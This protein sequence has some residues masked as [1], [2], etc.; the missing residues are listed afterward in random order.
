MLTKMNPLG[1]VFAHFQTLKNYD[2]DSLSKSELAFHLFVPAIF[3]YIQYN[4]G[5]A[6]SEN[7]ISI[8][9]SAASI[10]AG[11]MLNL[12]VLIYTLIFNSKMNAKSISNYSDFLILCKET[13]ST[14]SYSVLICIILVVFC[15]LNLSSFLNLIDIGRVGTV[16]LSI[17]AIFSLLIVLKRCYTIIQFDLK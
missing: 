1:I 5:S 16:Y 3:S 14:I 15:F 17:S 13:L 6:L 4:W 7:V 2:S 9:V 8:L 12:L 10:F 11:L